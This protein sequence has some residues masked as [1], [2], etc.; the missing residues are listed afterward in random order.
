[1]AGIREKSVG[2][3]GT[4]GGKQEGVI[5]ERAT[6]RGLVFASGAAEDGL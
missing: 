6:G 3:G 1:M 2:V 5:L 4:F